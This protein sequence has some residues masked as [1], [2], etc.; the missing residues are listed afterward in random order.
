MR[1]I[2]FFDKEKHTVTFLNFY[3]VQ[4]TNQFGIPVVFQDVL[5]TDSRF[6]VVSAPYGKVANPGEEWPH[7]NLLFNWSGVDQS[8][9]NVTMLVFTNASIQQ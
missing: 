1:C 6:E 5:L 3:C 4:F 8:L 9:R 7:V 2:V